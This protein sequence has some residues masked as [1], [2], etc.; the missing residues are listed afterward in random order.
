MSK[1]NVT[2]VGNLVQFNEP[3]GSTFIVTT[4][5]FAGVRVYPYFDKKTAEAKMAIKLFFDMNG[6]DPIVYN[7]Y[8]YEDEAFADANKVIRMM[9]A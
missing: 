3:T 5:S 7:G 2:K 1:I 9:G 8:D 4:E 6:Q